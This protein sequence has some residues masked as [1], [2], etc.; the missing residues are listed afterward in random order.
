MKLN[1]DIKL[2][3]QCFVYYFFKGTMGFNELLG[4]DVDYLDRVLNNP[5]LLYNCFEIYAA[6]AQLANVDYTKELT[7]ESWV[8]EYLV[9]LHREE[10]PET[11]Y[12]K[13]K[14]HYSALVNTAF[15]TEFLKLAYCFCKNSFPVSLQKS[16]LP[17]LNGSGTDAV[18]AFAVWTNVLEVDENQR[19]LNAA[20][21]LQRANERILCWEQ[22]PNK[23]FED[24]E[25]EQEIY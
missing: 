12:I 18:L 2:D 20:Y 24:W 14:A 3:I 16:Y 22:P 1:K 15:W 6:T 13:A 21:A 23:P 8:V 10:D 9:N 5:P 17:H 4:A 25:L 19:P 11:A 7:P